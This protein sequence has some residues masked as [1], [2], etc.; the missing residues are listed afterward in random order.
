MTTRTQ[1]GPPPLEGVRRILIVR[2][3]ALGDTLMSSPAAQVIKEAFPECHI[4]WVVGRHA[5]PVLEGNPY[6]DSVYIW[7]G[8]LPSVLRLIRELKQGQFDVSLDLQGLIKSA[9]IPWVARIPQRITF[10]NSREGS[11]FLATQCVTVNRTIPT[12]SGRTLAML[13]SLGLPVNPSRHRMVLYLSERHRQVAHQQLTR[14]NLA[15]KSFVLLA[16]ATTRPQKHWTMDRWAQCA[17]RL[18][19]D[20]SLPVVLLGSAS[21][22][23]LLETISSLAQ[24]PIPTLWHLSVKEA[25]AVIEQAL[26]VIGTDS[27]PIHASVALGTRTV[28]LF[29]STRGDRFAG[30]EGVRVVD[31]PLPCRPCG[32]RPTC[33]GLFPCM[34]LITVDEVIGAVESLLGLTFAER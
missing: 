8:G 15:P 12:P 6:I 31:H 2:L 22:R 18:R 17:D 25:C 10:S 29:G 20:L 11:R 27:F 9:L 33:G 5:Y 26:L 16:P 28:A 3:S 32:R 14:R 24:S 7:D 21:D 34:R 4:S 19:R 1:S 13:A 30:E 23:P